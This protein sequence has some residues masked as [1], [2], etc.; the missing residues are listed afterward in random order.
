MFARTL[1][2][3]A[4]PACGKIGDIHEEMIGSPGTEV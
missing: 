1:Q 2:A 3:A 4:R